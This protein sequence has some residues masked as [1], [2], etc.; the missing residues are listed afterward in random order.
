MSCKKMK[1]TPTREISG[2]FE[3]EE[4]IAHRGRKGN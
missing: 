1:K 4:L 2:K 3:V